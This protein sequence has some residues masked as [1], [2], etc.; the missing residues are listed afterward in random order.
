VQESLVDLEGVHAKL[1][2]KRAVEEHNQDCNVKFQDKFQ[3]AVEGMQ[4]Q[5]QCFVNSQK[6][7][8]ASLVHKTGMYWS[9][10]KNINLLLKHMTYQQTVSIDKSNYCPLLV[11]FAYLLLTVIYVNLI[12]FNL[13]GLLINV[14]VLV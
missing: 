11:W 4:E 9:V 7:Y 14:Q 13:A 2:R 12:I 1:D 8:N 10:I 6:S 5:L 3:G